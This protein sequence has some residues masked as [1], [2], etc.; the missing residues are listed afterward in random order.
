M[1]GLLISAINAQDNN[2]V[3]ALVLIYSSI[4]ILGLF[5]GDLMMGVLDPRIKLTKSGGAR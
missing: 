5:L 2:L 1:G 3:Q 4:G